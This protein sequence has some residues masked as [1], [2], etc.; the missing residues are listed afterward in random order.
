MSL[1]QEAK[2][3]TSW[4]SGSRNISGAVCLCVSARPPTRASLKAT[5]R[6]CG[7]AAS[8]RIRCTTT[9][10]SASTPTGR[11]RPSWSTATWRSWARW[12]TPLTSGPKKTSRRSGRGL[13]SPV[14]PCEPHVLFTPPPPPDGA[15]LNGAPL[16]QTL[17]HPVFMPHSH[18]VCVGQHHRQF[19]TDLSDEAGAL[20][21]Q[22][23]VCCHRG[24]RER[25][26]DR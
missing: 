14:C 18:C 21:V 23:W 26:R 25:S 20:S 17:A 16:I 4:G 24:H 5:T 9:A 11:T 12:C 19:E 10:G 7:S 6:C 13:C 1:L 2:M 15:Q 3:S 22:A 8:C